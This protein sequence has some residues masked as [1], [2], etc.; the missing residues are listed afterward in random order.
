[1][2][3]TEQ[4]SQTE[5][6]QEQLPTQP[7][8]EPPAQD[9]NTETHPLDIAALMANPELQAAISAQV[10]EGIKNALKGQTPK[11]NT[12]L[13]SVTQKSEFERMT[14]RERVQLFK[15]NPQEYHKLA[16]GGI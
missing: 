10:Q 5:N 13:P 11:A 9:T 3:Q 16:K 1:M 6:N 2:E 12:V 14:Y 7:P 15:N 4:G 8:A